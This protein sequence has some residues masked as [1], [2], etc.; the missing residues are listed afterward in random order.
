M[1]T[2]VEDVDFVTIKRVRYEL[3]V[4]GTCMVTADEECDDFGDYTHLIDLSEPMV[5]GRTEI[6]SVERCMDDPTKPFDRDAWI[7]QNGRPSD[8]E[9]P[10]NET[11]LEEF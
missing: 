5:V 4:E 8:R 10:G 9:R 6:G 3:Y 7:A 11:T 2:P 1:T